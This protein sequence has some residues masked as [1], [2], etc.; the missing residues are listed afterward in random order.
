M[1]K[2]SETN[3]PRASTRTGSPSKRSR[4]RRKRKAAAVRARKGGSRSWQWVLVGVVVVAAG[5]VG[6][7]LQASRSKTENTK[8]V[9]PKAAMGP[10]GSVAIGS[11]SA[12]VLLE[13]YGDFQCPVCKEFYDAMNPTIQQLVTNGT[14]RFAFHPLNI[15]DAHSPGSTESVRA[16]SASICAND[17]G[18]FD[19]YYNLLYE[20]QAAQENSGF[21]TDSRLVAFGSQA[22]ITG[23]ALSTFTKCV[24]AHTYEGYVLKYADIASKAPR[25][26]SA[27][28]TIFL[29]GKEVSSSDLVSGSNFDPQKLQALVQ[30][31]A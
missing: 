12:K 23:N 20:N 15:I 10:S 14:V 5:V 17:A 2:Q 30:Q 13:E 19:N 29:N 3:R 28:P 9:V 7:A 16:A 25:S 1:S 26:V 31:A 22:G 21:L 4:Q 27:T 18:K 24:N 6:V 11:K 8:V